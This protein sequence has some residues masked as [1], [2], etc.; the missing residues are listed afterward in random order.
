MLAKK[1]T[2][3]DVNLK[4]MVWGE[5]GSGKSRF[6][7]SAPAPLVI[8]LE[9]STRLYANEFDFWKA[10]V[11][12]TN[13][14][15][16]NPGSLTINL[17]KEILE[18]KY[19]D[20]KT[21]IIDPV[22]D[23]LDCIE[24]VSAKKYEEMIG[25]KVT[26]L[27]AVQKTKWYAYRR[28]TARNILNQLKDIPMNLIL[29][30]R[31]KN[32]WDTKDGKMQPVG[33]TYDALDIVEYLMDI[34]IQLEKNGD[35]TRAIV[36]KS[37]LGNLPKILD[38]KNFNSIG[39]AL[40]QNE[41][42]AEKNEETGLKRKVMFIA[43][44]GGHLNELMQLKPMFKK[45]NSYIITEYDE[46][47]KGLKEEYKNKIS[48]LV[49]GTRSNLFS[50]IFKFIYNCFKSLFLYLKIRPKYIISTGTHTA[51]PMCYIGK[52]FG[53]KII[54]I[55]TFANIKT[56]TLSGKLIYPIADLFIVQWEEM[57]KLYPKA[58]LGGSIY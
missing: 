48:Y 10:E 37:R 25:K 31:A 44:T 58:I 1:A 26:E 32:L 34:V 51:V 7:L 33:L 15:A 46:S 49:Y 12:K 23:L 24:D 14:Q 13:P 43:S 17:L 4:I 53:S 21:L 8:D 38:V 57:L 3:E 20:R 42:L 9:G 19:P 56:K 2:L 29:V 36:K 45:Y 39:Q 27:N 18:G 6:A 30:A 35:E 28:E 55:E 40:E 16:G 41:K 50:Y 22:T 52:I 5:S 54:F 47:T 11:D